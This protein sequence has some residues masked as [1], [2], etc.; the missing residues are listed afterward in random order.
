MTFFEY[1]GTKV[2]GTSSY[3]TTDSLEQLGTLQKDIFTVS[4]APVL[5]NEFYNEYTGQ[6]GY[7][8]VNLA[9]LNNEEGEDVQNPTSVTITLAQECI[10]YRDYKKYTDEASKKETT[11]TLS[12]GQGAFIVVEEQCEEV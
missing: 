5:V 6:Y 11:I 9:E 1:Q 2:Y 4:G 10:A 12:G 8:V 7:Y 3:V